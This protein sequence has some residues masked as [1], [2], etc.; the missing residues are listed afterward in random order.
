MLFDWSIVFSPPSLVI[1]PVS[2]SRSHAAVFSQTLIL[3]R[4]ISRR[5]EALSRCC[6]FGRRFF[7]VCVALLCCCRVP[8]QP[9]FSPSSSFSNIFSKIRQVRWFDYSSFASLQCCVVD[10]SHSSHSFSPH[11]LLI[12]KYFFE[13]STGSLVRLFFVRFVPPPALYF[14]AV[15]GQSCLLSSIQ[16]APAPG[17]TVVLGWTRK[18][19]P[20]PPPPRQRF[21]SRSRELS[22]LQWLRTSHIAW[23]S[24][25]GGRRRQQSQ[26]GKTQR[27][28]S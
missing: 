20:Q 11:I 6:F 16:P 24:G 5:F 12:F 10:E 13:N 18:P 25:H 28:F 19:R 23:A 26:T 1:P 4:N 22:P 21:S 2:Y 17:H 27:Y 8:L 15:D 3:M 7:A 9:Q 14:S